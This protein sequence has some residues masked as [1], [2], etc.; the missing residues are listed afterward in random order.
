VNSAALSLSAEF[1]DEAMA[2]TVLTALGSGEREFSAIGRAA[3]RVSQ[4]TLKKALDLLI[5]K[6]MVA[7]ETPLS[8]VAKPKLTRY[9]IA[10]PYL[11]LRGKAVEPILREAV[12][13]LVIIR[14]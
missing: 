7:V 11:R 5:D 8:T 14:L 10:D 3:G 1:P 12:E 2:R 4:T 9:R 13:P 6:R